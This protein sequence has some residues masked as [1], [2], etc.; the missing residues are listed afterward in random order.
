[1][2]ARIVHYVFI[3]F[4][5]VALSANGQKYNVRN[6]TTRDG[7][8]GQIVNGVFQDKTGYIWFATQSGVCFFNGKSFQLFEPSLELIGIDAVGVIQDASD[9]IWIATNANGVF[10]YDFKKIKNF[11]EENGLQSNIVRSIFID[12]DDVLW[13][14]TSK[15]VSKVIDNKLQAVKDTKGVFKNGVLSMTQSNDGVLWFGTQG[16]G[17]VKL[18]KGQFSY[19]N[20]EQ[21]LLDNYIFSLNTHGDS[22]LLGTT[23]QGLLVLKNGNITKL[24][25]PEIENEWI[26]NVIINGDA[27]YI[28]SSAG[29]IEYYNRKKY[30]VITELNGIASNDLYRGLKDRENNIWLASGNGVS[31]LRNEKILSFDESSGLS[32]DKI[33]SIAALKNKRLVVGTYGFGLN[34]LDKSG[35]IIRQI[36]PPEL[37]NIKITSIVDYPYKNELWIGAE[38]SEYGVVIL[39]TKNDSFKVKKIITSIDGNELKTITKLGIDGANNI[40][41]GTY[42]AGLFRIKDKDTLHYGKSKTFPANEVM[43]FEIDQNNYPWVSLYQKGVYAFDGTNFISISKTKGV[44]DKITLSI[45]NDDKGNMY[46]G[47]KTEGLTIITKNK[48]FS[49]TVRDGLLSNSIQSVVAD[50]NSVWVGSSLGINKLTFSDDFELLKIETFNEKTGLINS[51]I[52]QNAILLA[53]ENVWICSSTGLSSILKESINRSFVKPLLELESIKLYFEN[54]NWSEKEAKMNKWGVPT[55]LNLGHKENHLTFSFNALT[56]TRVQYSFKLEGQDQ[57]WT[58]YDEKS[59]VTF[60]NIAPGEYVFKVKAIN[61][62]GIESQILEIP[63][64]IRS[65]Y[66]QTWW[67]RIAAVGAIFLLIFTF[68]RYR[69][70]RFKI[71]QLKLEVIVH[72]RTKE[73]VEASELAERQKEIVEQKNKEILDSISYAKRIQTAMLPTVEFLNGKFKEIAVFYRPK[74]IVA[75]DFYWFEE[76]DTHT[77]IAVADC[78]GH[79]VPGAMVSVVCYNALNR[80]VREYG[81]TKPGEILDRTREIILSELSKHDENVKDGMDISLIVIEKKSRKLEWAGANNPLWIIS[82]YSKELV[83]IKADKQPIG[84]H[85]RSTPFKTHQ[86]NLEKGDTLILLT[87]GFADQFGMETGKKFKSANL[88]RL[89]SEHASS[90]SE[91]ENSMSATFENWKGEEEQVDDVCIIALRITL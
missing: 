43:T 69:E 79:G 15:G 74:D 60:S 83:E 11:N 16:S 61:N 35:N 48:T 84:L 1:M 9:R 51:E 52:Q 71:Q 73:A 63:I 3:F 80:S 57:N 23:N 59:E 58:A 56:S 68:V 28:V 86:V 36:Q 90:M 26:S 22:I 88:K 32:D 27:L 82:A 25:V 46:F 5:L 17:L 8:A 41:I 76:S 12:R 10:V 45:S 31:L 70:R 67:F 54:V 33:T 62:F 89:L 75:G 13:I 19:F 49:F 65:P 39:D 2:A 85:I 81:L 47:N 18:S 77:M 20:E 34:L 14:L 91:L 64:V 66:W 40:W 6:Y 87:D 42:D 24:K 30:T 29:L 50:G 21:G 4:F 53:G 37:M 72:E 44:K 7:L 38:Q 55:K 78:T